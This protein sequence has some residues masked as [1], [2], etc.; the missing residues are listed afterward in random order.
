MDPLVSVV[1]S[2]YNR[3]HIVA[4]AV[5]SVL[6]QSLRDFELIVVDDGST[7][8]TCEVISGLK[9]ER[10]CYVY[11]PNAG[12]AAG[13]NAGIAQ[14]KG[15]YVAFIDD[16]DFLTPDSLAQ[17]VEFLQNNPHVGWVSGGHALVNETGGLLGY[18]RPWLNNLDLTPKMWLYW[19]PTC[20]SA[21][22]VQ[23]DWL[24]QVDGF[25]S[26]QGLQE[27]W[28]LWLRLAFAGCPMAWIPQVV[29]HY[30]VHTANMTRSSEAIHATNGLLRVLE[31][32]YS[33]DNL[34]TEILALR[35]SA[36]AHSYL[37]LASAAFA[38]HDIGTAMHDIE[39]ERV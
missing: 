29:C 10:I 35:D 22:M 23:R 27:D 28:D 38:S 33:Q 36:Y 15:K 26:Q 18:S 31:K 30:Q 34:Q 20:P 21:V 9:D 14:A 25:D 8:N 5:Q 7:D 24:N 13:R 12:L 17:R 11:Q 2:T 3:A 37:K 16:D 1:M 19:C 4:I 39:R 32:L 6:A